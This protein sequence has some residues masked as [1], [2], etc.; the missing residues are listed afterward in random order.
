MS[1]T[2][3]AAVSTPSAAYAQRKARA[4]I[5]WL[6]EAEGVSWVVGRQMS[7]TPSELD[8]EK[9]RAARAAVAARAPGIDQRN[10]VAAVPS[11]VDD[12]IAQLRA[13]PQSAQI[14]A[15]SGEPKLVDLARV[16]AAQKIIYTDDATNR[17][18]GLRK[19]DHLAIAQV[20]LP[21]ASAD[22]IPFIF[23]E[24]KNS[25]LASSPNPNLRVAGTLHQP[26][27][28]GVIACGFV[29]ALHKSYV[30]VAGVNGRYFLRDGYHRAF[31]LLAAGISHAVVLVREFASFEEVGMPQGL[32]PPTAYLGDKP[33]LL[34]DYLDDSLSVDTALPVTTK[35]VVV[36]AL[37]LNS[38]G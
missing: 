34:V 25:W 22:T 33:P 14:L 15:E 20:T 1:T 38:I 13:N 10:L 28:P 29:V 35:M 32:L 2:T 30:Q 19:D 5:G 18:V 6:P 9:C 31:G 23:D 36:Q 27:A 21:L 11:I 16:C 37:E 4:L 26:V 8:I 7:Q 3:Q 17:V 12:H 24:A